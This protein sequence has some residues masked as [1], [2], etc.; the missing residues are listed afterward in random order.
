MGWRA[1]E[2]VLEDKLDYV[3]LPLLATN[4]PMMND[5]PMELKKLTIITAAVAHVGYCV[6]WLCGCVVLA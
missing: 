3:L 5:I 1:V 2:I 6:L 4:E